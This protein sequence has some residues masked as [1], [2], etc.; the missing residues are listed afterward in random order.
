ME[1]MLIKSTANLIF[2]S[3]QI[4]TNIGKNILKQKMWETNILFL[5]DAFYI[6]VLNNF[7]SQ[8]NA[9]KSKTWLQSNS[10]QGG[11]K[12]ASKAVQDPI[13]V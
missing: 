5:V 6:L 4:L 2:Q 11:L 3:T 13:K 8:V 10:V 7:G 9:T 1:P 12:P